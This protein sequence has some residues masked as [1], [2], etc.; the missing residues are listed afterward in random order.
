MLVESG[1]R[2]REPG[3][4]LLPDARG[5]LLCPTSEG[6]A[7]AIRADRTESTPAHAR[8]TCG[9]GCGVINSAVTADAGE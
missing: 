1:V 5:N 6:Q 3:A 2:C 7:S 8:V 4:D 9:P